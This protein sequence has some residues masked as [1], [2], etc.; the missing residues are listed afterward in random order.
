[1][2]TPILKGREFLDSDSVRSEPAVIVNEAFQRLFA[3]GRSLVGAQVLANNRPLNVVGVAHDVPGGTLRDDVRPAMYVPLAQSGAT[4]MLSAQMTMVVRT[5]GI[6]PATVVP[7]LR[8]AIWA[9]DRNAVLADIT[10]LDDRVASS[11]RTERQSA[12]VFAALAIIALVIAA[13]GVYGVATYAVAQRT[14]ELGIRITLGA[15]RRTIVGLVLRQAVT[16]ALVGIGLGIPVAAA[17]TRLL[18]SMLYGVTALDAG[19]FAAAAAVLAIAAFV[20]TIAPTRRVLRLDP[21]VA[22]RSD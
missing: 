19:S 1:M 4:N 16:P 14:K 6:P 2:R 17:S 10:T 8:R 9:L 22:L 21:L 13:I 11:L 18:A 3:D 7:G 20:A 12:I 15:N 5:L